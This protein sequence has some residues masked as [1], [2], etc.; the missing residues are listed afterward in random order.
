MATNYRSTEDTN[1][2]IPLPKGHEA[3]ESRCLSDERLAPTVVA[4]TRLVFLGVTEIAPSSSPSSS[5]SFE[6][7]GS[8]SAPRG[9]G[10]TFSAS[11]DCLLSSICTG[12]AT[13][14]DESVTVSGRTEDVPHP[15]PGST[16]VGT[17][18]KVVAG[19]TSEIAGNPPEASSSTE[20]VPMVNPGRVMC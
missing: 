4:R 6:E 13:T 1:C 20:L 11:R 12:A 15:A 5:P 18:L 9:S 3:S 2:L 7:G 14:G 16:D 10:A 19:N 8:T 17:V